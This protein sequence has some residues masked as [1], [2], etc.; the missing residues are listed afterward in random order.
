MTRAFTLSAAEVAVAMTAARRGADVAGFARA[1][2][3]SRTLQAGDLFFAIRGPRF[4]GHDFLAGAVGRGA[5]GV[6][7]SDAAALDALPG[8]VPAFVVADTVAALQALAAEV[9]RRSGARVVA[10]TGSAG[11]TT[12][13]ENAAALLGA[14][15]A[16]LRN[17]GNLNNHL[18]LPLS[19]LELTGGAEVAVMELG[20]NHAGEIRRLVEIA[21][22][23]VR[24]WTNVGTAHLEFFGTADAIADA[25]AE[26]LEAAGPDTVFVANADDARVMA[27]AASFPGRTVAFGIEAPADI[28]ATAVE[29]AGFDGLR[30]VVETPAGRVVIA[31]PLAGRAHLLNVLAAIAVALDADV[32]LEAMPAR[33]AALRPA[34]HRGEVRRLARDVVVVDD[35]YNAS[36]AALQQLLAVAAR[37]A[38]GRRRVAYLGEMLE[39]GSESGALHQACGRS[40]A[41]SGISALVT[42]GG[43][44][45]RALG[46]AAREAGLEA[47]SLWHHDTSEDAAARLDEVVRA[48]DLVLV[49]G[50]RGTRMERVVERLVEAFD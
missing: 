30:A 27:R 5:A 1:S 43:A 40:V 20:M 34:A 6:V 44:P 4:D 38:S 21:R 25:K 48:G 9:R 10:I 35:A 22:P 49:K 46:M 36:P 24:V 17:R 50:S 26:I 2:I 13:K 28:R 29:D 15:H 39:L 32:P 18:G 45:A 7:V 3:D 19:L 14:R 11:K 47:G 37:D 33:I 42:V 12:T 23:D 31:S 8:T 16:T 41:A